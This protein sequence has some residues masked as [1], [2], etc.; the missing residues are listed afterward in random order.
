MEI[1]PAIDIYNGQCVRLF[2]GR[3]GSEKTYFKN[4]IDAVNFWINIGAKRLHVIDLNAAWG[5][6]INNKIIEEVLKKRPSHIKVQIGGGIRSLKKALELIEKGADKIILG[7]MAIKKPQI[8]DLILKEIGTER[9]IIAVDYKKDQLMVNGWNAN[10]DIDPFSFTK[11][12]IKKGVK[13]ILFSNIEADGTLKGPDF[14][15][16]RKM[17]KLI[18]P[19]HLIVAGGVRDIKDVKELG[20]INVHGVVIGKAFYERKIPFG[21]CRELF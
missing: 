4:V 2:R 12:I 8:I 3:K 6:D 7:T 17:V 9:V 10:Y 16:I 1:I 5:S 15:N 13:Y 11:M 18:K 21:I 19:N 20:K 14:S